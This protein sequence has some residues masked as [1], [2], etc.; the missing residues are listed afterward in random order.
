MAWKA[1]DIKNI[2]HWKTPSGDLSTADKIRKISNTQ[3]HHIDASMIDIRSA[4]QSFIL[5]IIFFT[6]PYPQK[7]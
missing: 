1:A 7:L 3:K 2:T 5:K 6:L 4:K